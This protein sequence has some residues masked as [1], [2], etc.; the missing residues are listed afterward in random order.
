MTPTDEQIKTAW[1]AFS[2]T[3]EFA[4]L[5]PTKKNSDLLNREVLA[6]GSEYSCEALQNSAHVLRDALDLKPTATVTQTPV[7]APTPEPDPNFPKQ[8]GLE[9]DWAF[10]QRVQQYR[11]AK[12]REE[13][14]QRRH[15]STPWVPNAAKQLEINM[16]RAVMA[17]RRQNYM[18][19]TKY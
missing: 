10:A 5:Q 12:L 2:K 14:Y 1:I 18:S 19:E 6:S 13:D 4:E 7:A 17:A 8:G 11:F 16:S 15:Q 3:P 9:S